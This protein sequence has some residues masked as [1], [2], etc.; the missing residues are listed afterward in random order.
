M[1]DYDKLA[2]LLNAKQDV[3]ISHRDVSVRLFT[4]EVLSYKHDGT[5]KGIQGAVARLHA[6]EPPDSRFTEHPG[7]PPW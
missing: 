2:E 6:G 3:S 1:S 7:T 4:G 5:G